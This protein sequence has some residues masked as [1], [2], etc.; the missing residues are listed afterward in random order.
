MRCRSGAFEVYEA[1]LKTFEKAS[2]ADLT[3]HNIEKEAKR[4]VLLAIKVPTIIDFAEV[5]KLKAVKHLQDVTLSLVK[6]LEKQG[7]V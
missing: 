1:Y 2:S 7:S 5:L 6:S 3:S 4:C